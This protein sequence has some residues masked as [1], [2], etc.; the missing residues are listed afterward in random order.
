MRKSF[1]ELTSVRRDRPRA[2]VVALAAL[3][4]GVAGGLA[5]AAAQSFDSSRRA[6]TADT[7]VK[8][9]SMG[10]GKSM[11]VDLPRDASEIFVGEPKVANAIVRSARRLY[12]IG[13]QGGQTTIFAMDKEGH[14]IATIELSVGRDIGELANI[15]KA[16]L[17]SSN[18]TAKTVND[19]IIL[20]GIVDSAG[21][22]QTAMDLAKGFT[23]NSG[24]AGENASG[25]VV[26]ALT[27][28]GRDQVM[29]KVTIAEI[30]RSVLKQL[31]VTGALARGSWGTI[32]AS[33]NFSINSSLSPSTFANVGNYANMA[34]AG[35]VIPG[36]AAQIQ[37]Y[38]NN[39]VARVLAEPTV[40]A[41]SGENAKF[42]V[43]GE[44]PVPAGTTCS[45]GSC[46]TGVTYKTYGVTLNF[47]PVVLAEGRIL[48]RLATEVAELDP[49]ITVNYGYGSITAFR[50]RK[51]ETSV[52][53][54]SGGSIVTAGLIETLSQSA[55][56]GLPG[57]MN[58]PILGALFRS[59]DYQRE[60]TE[61]LIAVTPYIAKPSKP[62]ELALPTDGFADAS[63][64]QA[65]LLGRFNR[66]YSTTTN[67]QVIEGFKGRFGFIND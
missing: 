56:N 21:D 2:G 27:I 6:V 28:R 66:I 5:P 65:V 48:L 59:R 37:A 67:P 47:T 23:Q 54:P 3:L 34:A 55:L 19:T 36:L 14:A 10:V 35:S 24:K 13:L 8:R 20:T 57:L 11:I 22:V 50:T 46:Q 38:E 64:P 9:I 26:N 39:G 60:E 53:L 51:N 45:N 12:L 1:H 63:D 15:L 41:V 17:P 7:M 42:T 40:T 25:M 43:G 58:L 33:N 49:T 62:S 44:I 16:A 32:S 61:L 30:R 52:E 18:I 29:L 31:G 4:L